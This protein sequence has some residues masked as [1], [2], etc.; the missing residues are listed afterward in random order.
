MT[1]NYHKGFFKPLYPEKYMGNPKSI[2]YRSHW[3]FVFLRKLDS[4]PDVI[5]YASEEFSIKYYS[6]VDKRVRRYFPDMY[7]ET[8]SGE[9]YLVEIKP[10]YQCIP[11]K[12][13]NTKNQRKLLSEMKTFSVNQAKWAAAKQWCEE[14]NIKFK[15]LT[16]KQLFPKIVKKKK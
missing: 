14:R 7:Y 9:K 12:S 10:E 11:P 15:I 6:P 8:K 4:D 1:R 16:E 13:K 5:K 2:I 3:E